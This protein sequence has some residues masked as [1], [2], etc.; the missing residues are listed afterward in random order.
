VTD[1]RHLRLMAAQDA[2]GTRV[3]LKVI[4]DGK[5]KA[6][7]VKLSELPSEGLGKTGQSGGHGQSGKKADLLEGVELADLDARSRRQ[8]N[9]PSQVR[10]GVLVVD[11]IR[12]HGGG[13]WAATRRC[14]PGNQPSAVSKGRGSQGVDSAGAR[15]YVLCACGVM[16]QPLC[17][18][19]RQ[20]ESLRAPGHGSP[21]RR[22]AFCD[23]RA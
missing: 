19:G 9:I 8:F 21:L 13:R 16:G 22:H 3:P 14:H 6:L 20:Q 10:G 12:A 15:R 17:G 11:V 4:R 1:S 23:S 7:T 2:A 5:E 18:R